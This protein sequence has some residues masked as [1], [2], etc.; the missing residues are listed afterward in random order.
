MS[1]CKVNITLLQGLSLSAHLRAWVRYECDI[2]L[3]LTLGARKQRPALYY[4]NEAVR[5]T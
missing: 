2:G 3:L 5:E 4:S 1:G